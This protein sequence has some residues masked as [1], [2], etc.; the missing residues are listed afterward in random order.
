[1]S[2]LLTILQ[3]FPYILQA[4]VAVEG[5]VS[6]PGATKKQLVLSSILNVAK[7]GEEVPQVTVS[8]ISSLIDSTVS[9]LNASGVFGHA[10]TVPAPA[11]SA[12]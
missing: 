3:Y 10:P 7:V 4:V 1:M 9:A 6:A 8:T 5:A 12:Q 2:T 11:T